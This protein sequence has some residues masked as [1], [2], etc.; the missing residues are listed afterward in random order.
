LKEN[1]PVVEWYGFCL[2]SGAIA[3][4][5]E[6]VTL[7]VANLTELRGEKPAI[8]GTPFGTDGGALN[9]LARV[10]ALMVGP[11]PVAT[12][13]RANEYV[14]VEQLMDSAKVIAMMLIDWC[15]CQE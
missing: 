4:D 15:G 6:L 8:V 5:H 11:G 2:N 7:A 13:H 1:P 14:E 12:A 9:R 10:P 3:V